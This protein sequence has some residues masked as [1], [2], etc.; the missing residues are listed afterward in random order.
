MLLKFNCHNILKY[1]GHKLGLNKFY[2]LCYNH[3]FQLIVKFL[4][5]F[6]FESDYKIPLFF[7]HIPILK[8]VI[9]CIWMYLWIDLLFIFDL[10][11]LPK[12]MFQCIPMIFII[13][14]P[15]LNFQWKVLFFKVPIF[16]FVCKNLGSL[17]DYF[18]LIMALRT[19]WF[20]SSPYLYIVYL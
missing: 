14:L 15:Y 17:L 19:P 13:N 10:L 20:V 4:L 6:K 3:F 8:I 5:E 12:H 1:Y 7:Y 16:K 2:P 9:Q 11:C 18:D